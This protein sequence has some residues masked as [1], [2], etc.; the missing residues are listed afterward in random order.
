[1]FINYPHTKCVIP[2]A[3][4]EF[5]NAVKLQDKLKCTIS[6]FVDFSTFS[7]ATNGCKGCVLVEELLP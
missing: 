7:A 6:R 5:V 1:M 3:G 4:F 2:A